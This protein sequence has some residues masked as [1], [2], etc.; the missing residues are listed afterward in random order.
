MSD[1][2]PYEPSLEA[3]RSAVYER[4]ASR[5]FRLPSGHAVLTRTEAR[6][7]LGSDPVFV[8][9]LPLPMFVIFEAT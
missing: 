2:R 7:L 9:D 4:A 3:E 1:W 6:P 8:R 5:T